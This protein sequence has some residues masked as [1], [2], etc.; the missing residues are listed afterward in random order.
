MQLYK[1]YPTIINN[2]FS[3]DGT[4]KNREAIATIVVTI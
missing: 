4:I 3:K 1:K 2:T